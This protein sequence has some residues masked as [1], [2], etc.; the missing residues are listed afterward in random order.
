[1]KIISDGPDLLLEVPGFSLAD[2]LDCG[3][4]FRWESAADGAFHG[5]HR[6]RSLTVSQEGDFLR[7]HRVSPEELKAFWNPYFD[8]DTD[9]PAMNGA[10]SA[11]PTLREACRCAGGIHILR[12]D[13]WEA[14]CSFIVSQNNNI[15]RIKGILSRLCEG[16]GVPCGDG[17]T[18]PGPEVLAAQTPEALAPLRA[19]FRVRYLLDA[20]R[21]IC[22]GQIDL[23]AIPRLSLNE[24]RSELMKI[25]GVG[26]KVADCTLLFGF[27]RLDAFPVDTWMKKALARYYPDGFP[28][29][30]HA[31][32]AQPYLFHYIRRLDGAQK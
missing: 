31:G 4:C 9:Y 18:F 23:S 3:Q 8:L 2:T 29:I 1:M 32:V 10:F 21:K 20:A 19:G 22:C 15:P 27:H 14:L 11:D 17:R 28:E 6:D 30:P 5:V 24:A 16:F 26:P 25:T 7:F 12:Q 13:P